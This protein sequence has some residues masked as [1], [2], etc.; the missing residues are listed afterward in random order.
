[1]TT[2]QTGF[3]Y[4]ERVPGVVGGDP[5]IKGTRVPVWII[6]SHWRMHG[7]L[8]DITKAYPHVSDEAAREALAYYEANREEIDEAITEN[9][10]LAYENIA[11]D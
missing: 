11:D 2:R 10:A 9:E 4:I 7:T 3:Q 6:V 1:V 8:A 5:K